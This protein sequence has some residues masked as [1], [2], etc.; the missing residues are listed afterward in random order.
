MTCLLRAGTYRETVT[1]KNDGRSG[2]PIVFAPATGE[3]AVVSGADVIGG[4]SVWKGS[5]YRATATLP[6]NGYAD[7]GFAANQVF[8]NGVAMTEARWPNTGVDPLT[9]TLKGCCVN[10]DGGDPLKVRITASDVPVLGAAWA[11]ATVWANEW[12]TTRTGTVSGGVAGDLTGTMKTDYFRNAYWFYLTGKLELLDAEREWHY[13]GS[14]GSVYLW[15]PG[16]SVPSGV[17]VKRR[18]VA[19]DLG[20]H[21][22]VQLKN[23]SI[24]AATITS[25]GASHDLV[26]DGIDAKYVSHHVTLPPLPAA[27]RNPLGDNNWSLVSHAHDSGIQLRGTGNTLKNSRVDGSAGNLVTV[28]GTRHTIENNILLTANYA[29]TYAA[30]VY[31]SGSEHKILHNTISGSGRSAITALFYSTGSDF[32]NNEI[33]YNDISRFG[34]LSSDLG[35]IYVCCSVNLQGTRI[36][37]NRIHSPFGYSYWW[38]VAGIYTDNDSYNVTVDHNVIYNMDVHFPKAAK[39]STKYTA[40]ELIYNNVFLAPFELASGDN[41]Y[42]VRN[43][44]FRQTA[45]G[46]G[47]GVSNNL[48]SDVDPLFVA[49]ASF[50]YRLGTGSPAIGGGVP[51]SGIETGRDVGAYPSGAPA[52][53]AGASRP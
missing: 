46:T 33:A 37:H 31:A 49:P 39:I 18:N 26:L 12:Y 47:P 19:F 53:T 43:N 21:S 27:F 6:V 30:S 52:W 10:M 51:V 11:G 24:F 35:A 20:G 44:I 42:T 22:Y 15:A 5:I 28:E 32:Q 48:F 17:E 50:D 13:D 3:V 38:D 1:V 45:G 23:L 7:E 16:G 40:S 14:T 4:W 41:R 9:P 25:T 36:H 2:E 29:S 34:A 8:V